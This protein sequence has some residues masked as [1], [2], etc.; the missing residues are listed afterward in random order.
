MSGCAAAHFD[1]PVRSLVELP[2]ERPD[3]SQRPG[4]NRTKSQRNVAHSGQRQFGAIW[5]ALQLSSGRPGLRAASV[6]ARRDRPRQRDPQCR[7]CRHRTRQRLRVRRRQF[8]GRAVVA[9]QLPQSRAGRDD[10]V[11]DRPGVRLHR[12]RSRHHRDARDRSGHRH[13]V[14]RRDDRRLQ[15]AATCI[16]CMRSTSPPAPKSPAARWKSKLP[17]PE[18]ATATPPFNS[19]LGC[20]RNEPACCC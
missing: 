20:T 15:P 11:G 14:C 1:S 7:L 12:A 3:L 13:F 17:F 10:S 8:P 16:G 18:P 4:T 6:S 19:S 5:P 2:G 9:H